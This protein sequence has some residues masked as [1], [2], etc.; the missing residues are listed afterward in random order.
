[1]RKRQPDGDQHRASER[2]GTSPLPHAR[3]IE[4]KGHIVDSHILSQVMDVVMDRDAEFYVGQM[5]IG[6]NKFDPSYARIAIHAA[7]PGALDELME[8]VGKL[9]AQM[10]EEGDARTAPAPAD[11]VLPDGFHCTTNMPTEVRID[12]R[13]TPVEGIEMDLAIALRPGGGSSGSGGPAGAYTVPM[14][15]VRT[16]TPIVVGHEG[17]RVLPVERPRSP[18]L[19]GSASR[20]PQGHGFSFMS[21]A[22]SS[23][24]PKAAAIAELAEQLRRI[25]AEGGRT[26]VVGGPAIVHTGAGPQFAALL[27]DGYI[28]LLFAGN[29]LAT[30]DIEAAIY[31]TSLGVSLDAASEGAALEHGH[32]HHL[33]TINT[34]RGLGGIRRAVERGVLTRGIMYECVRHNVPYVLAGSIRDDGPLPDTI[35]D[36]IEAQR[37]MRAHI[38]AAG[39][40]ALALLLGTTLHA[41]AVGNL[42]PAATLTVCVDINPAVVT[43]LLDRGS[44]QTAG[45][46]IGAGG[47]LRELAAHLDVRA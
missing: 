12:G 8:A 30:H 19:L 15:D 13:W 20:G 37:A 40:V 22:V 34:I 3:T 17:V 16:G 23:E 41:V 35:T 5:R 33:R 21:S 4:L 14:A 32:E 42:L 7:T 9:G 47:F 31:G 38:Q 25:R 24:R 18:A 2:A 26:L 39:G 36:V 29:A 45:L 43:K 10:L 46:V 28:N 6:R 1:M 11:G 44:L 27:R